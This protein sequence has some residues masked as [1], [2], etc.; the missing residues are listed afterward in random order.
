M[1]TIFAKVLKQTQVNNA[2]TAALTI[3]K[4]EVTGVLSKVPAQNSR[5]ETTN[6]DNNTTSL[7]QLQDTVATTKII[8]NSYF[9]VPYRCVLNRDS[10]KAEMRKVVLEIDTIPKGLDLIVSQSLKDSTQLKPTQFSESIFSRHLL[11]TKKIEPKPKPYESQNWL[12]LIFVLVLFLI[13]ILRVFYQK[14]FM[15]FINAFVSK[16]FSNQ[17]I[18][19][20]NAISQS[21]S[22]VLSIVFFIS[23]SVFFYSASRYFHL[24]YSE[25]SDIQYFFVIL[26]ACIAFYFLKFLLNKLGGFIFKA[27]KETDEYIFNQ[28]LVIQILGLL[29][30]IWCILLNYSP[31]ISKEVII[32]IGFGTLTIGFLVRM[33]KG[34]GIANMNSYSPVYIFLYLCTLEILPLIII[35][36]LIIR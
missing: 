29:L 6:S 21:T 30:T 28:F 14:K 26:L 22:V 15:L 33:I 19:E 4:N 12:V 35:V 8:E 34:F 31:K 5:S 9:T 10:L 16:R 13:G 18:R 24:N 11:I 1:Y 2:D 7:K 23:I 3:N 27:Y 36:K 25:Y 20:E 32:Y 17:I